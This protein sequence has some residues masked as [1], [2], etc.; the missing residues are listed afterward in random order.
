M[1]RVSCFSRPGDGPDLAIVELVALGFEFGAPQLTTRSLLDTFDGRL[2]RAGARLDA[3]PVYQPG[4]ADAVELFPHGDPLPDRRIIVGRMP[5]GPDDVPAGQLRSQLVALI[6]VRALLVRMQMTS[7]CVHAL[8]RNADGKAVARLE[9]HTSIAV[10]AGGLD[11]LDLQEVPIDDGVWCLELHEVPEH[12]KHAARARR[13]LETAGHDLVDTDA[14]GWAVELAGVDLAGVDTSTRVR[15]RRRARA[16]DAYR[17]VL[18]RLGEVVAAT[19]QGSADDVDPEFLHDLRVALRR[20]RTVLKESKRVLPETSRLDAIALAAGLAAATGDARD[21]DVHLLGWDDYVATAVPADPAD[22]AD[23]ANPAAL[24][25]VRQLLVERQVDAHRLLRSTFDDIGRDRWA[26][27]WH[28]L[29]DAEPLLADHPPD[30]AGRRVG[31]VI[32]DRLERA[33]RRLV[34]DGRRIRADSPSEHFHELRKD[35]KRIRSLVECFGS[36]VKAPHRREFVLALKTLQ[37]HLGVLQDTTVQRL[38]IDDFVRELQSAPVEV[39]Q[40]LDGLADVL[41]ELHSQLRQDFVG[42]FETFDSK[43]TRRALGGVLDGLR[44]A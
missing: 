6:D 14:L 33:H 30:E 11:P 19:W 5:R 42:V 16:D 4:A 23:P 25:P 40:A 26:L 20:A 9:L 35:A 1:T 3:R 32:A 34:R 24:A 7:Q 43:H 17:M 10:A 21:L 39:R 13:R 18:H 8:R 44:P 2:H 12:P 38:E 28:E 27:R 36:L 37:D 31:K 22:P 29:I 15:L 41:D